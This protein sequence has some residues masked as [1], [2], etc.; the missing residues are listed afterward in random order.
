MFTNFKD[1]NTV[2]KKAS[3][4]FFGDLAHFADSG[5]LGKPTGRYFE[6]SVRN[7][8]DAFA[9]DFD[10]LEERLTGTTKI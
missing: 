2:N 3:R 4:L 7:V 1:M 6:K 5:P 10:A 8:Y 9:G